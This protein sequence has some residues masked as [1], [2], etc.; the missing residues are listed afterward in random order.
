MGGLL[1]FSAIAAQGLLSLNDTEIGSYDLGDGAK[2]RTI[3]FSTARA[4][5]KHDGTYGTGNFVLYCSAKRAAF[6]HV[7]FHRANVGIMP[8]HRRLPIEDSTRF[9]VMTIMYTLP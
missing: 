3:C 1:S 4:M 8:H 7:F 2:R 6:M 9:P 5:T